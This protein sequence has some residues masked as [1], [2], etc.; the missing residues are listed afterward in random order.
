M[1][2]ATALPSKVCDP[3]PAWKKITIYFVPLSSPLSSLALYFALT[4]NVSHLLNISVALLH[5]QEE[6]LKY[7][8][9]KILTFLLFDEVILS[10]AVYVSFLFYFLSKRPVNVTWMIAS[11][12]KLWVVLSDLPVSNAHV[13]YIEMHACNIFY[14]KNG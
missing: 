1:Q 14:M 10:D 4:I 11:N 12:K 7:E 8:V 6:S 13:C 2:W 5:D 3:V 9:T